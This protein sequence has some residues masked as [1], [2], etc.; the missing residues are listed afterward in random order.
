LPR[1]IDVAMNYSP[2]EVKVREATNGEEQWGPHGSVM[3]DIA[4]VSASNFFFC[5][6][7]LCT[8]PLATSEREGEMFAM[9]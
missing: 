8:P 1:S 6:C 7:F 5:L 4:K 3:A 2:I 9:S